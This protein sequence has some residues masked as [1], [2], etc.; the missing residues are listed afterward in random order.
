MSLAAAQVKDC[1]PC[2]Y[3]TYYKVQSNKVDDAMKILKDYQNQANST[4]RNSSYLL[5]RMY[6]SYEY[7]IMLVETWHLKRNSSDE[8]FKNM[9]SLMNNI[10]IA[11][12]IDKEHIILDGGWGYNQDITEGIFTI[13][14]IDTIPQAGLPDFSDRVAALQQYA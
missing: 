1:A 12:I 11:P 5:P 13:T 9:V 8:A 3:L 2:F 7:Q 14:H 6:Q 10:V 4:L